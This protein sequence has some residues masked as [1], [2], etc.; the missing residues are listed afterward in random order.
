MSQSQG[1]FWTERQKDRRTE[2]QKDGQTDANS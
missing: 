2:G 1:N